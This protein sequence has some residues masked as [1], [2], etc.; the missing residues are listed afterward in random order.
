MP[1]KKLLSLL[2]LCSFVC[3]IAQAQTQEKGFLHLRIYGEPDAVYRIDENIF[4]SPDTTF[5]LSAGS[6]HV[7]IWSPK[8]IMRD[9]VVLVNVNDTAKYSFM[10]KLLPEYIQYKKDYAEFM[11]VRNRR[12]FVSPIWMGI[13]IGTGIFVNKQFAQKQYN[14][15]LDAKTYYSGTGNQS[16]MDEEKANFATY[17]RKYDNLKKTEYGIYGVSAALFVNYI[18]IL[19]R[20]KN[21]PVPQFTERSAFSRLH[22]NIYPDLENRGLR[23][24]LRI[25]L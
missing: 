24:G 10:L 25:E 22:F 21:T 18:R 15:A 1:L 8:T 16:K 17:K 5:M 13:T 11:R 4:R 12:F 23:Y 2:V 7:K 6:H 3:S 9:T 20:Q 19:I 14:K